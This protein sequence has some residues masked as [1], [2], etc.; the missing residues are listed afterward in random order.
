MGTLPGL[1]SFDG[2]DDGREAML[3]GEGAARIGSDLMI[4][5]LSPDMIA[6]FALRSKYL[7]AMGCPRK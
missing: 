6:P 1:L 3:E 5:M 2:L 4:L 7:R